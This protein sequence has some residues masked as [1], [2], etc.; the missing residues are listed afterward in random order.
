[1]H[2]QVPLPK[3]SLS[4]SCSSPPLGGEARRGGCESS[5]NP[6]SQPLPNGGEEKERER[7]EESERLT[8]T[9]GSVMGNLFANRW[10]VV[11]ASVLG[12]LVGSGPI[13]IFSSGVFLKPV[14]AELGITRGDLSIA[15]LLAALCTAVTLPFFGWLL[16]R[17]GTR[18]V[19]MPGIVLYAL[20]VAAFGLMERQPAFVIPMIY[21]LVGII[22]VV[23]TPIPYAAVVAQWFDRQRGLALGIATAGVGLGVVVLPPFLALLINNFGWRHAYYGLGLAVLLLAWLPVALFVR[24]PPALS[25]EAAAHTDR[26]LT[27]ALPGTHASQAFRQWEFWALTIA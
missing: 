17:V 15:L 18:R 16:D 21:A 26:N 19:M 20:A 24:E 10:L 9:W 4:R 7:G 27:D 3:V 25:R 12:L 13:L 14:S 5:C 22:G 1:M 8:R 2:L 6:H 23:Q 11:F